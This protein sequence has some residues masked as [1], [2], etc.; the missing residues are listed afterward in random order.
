MN[1]KSFVKFLVA[2]STASLIAPSILSQS[3]IAQTSYSED[4]VSFYCGEFLDK[5]S[6]E[7][8]PAT[9]AY[10]PQ[11]KEHISI[12]AWKSDHIPAWDA[13]TRCKTVSPK[14]QAFYQ[15]G[16][17][18]YLG[19]GINNGENVICAVVEEGQSCNPEDQLFQVKANDNPQAVLE[20]LTGIIQGDSSDPIYQSTGQ[21]IYVSMEELLNSAP[22][23]E[24]ADLTSN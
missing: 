1:T 17:L 2:T 21:Q 15:D 14:F 7:K 5:T 16:R 10:V 12:I 4:G 20:G 13:Q 19:T 11:R 22:A 3:S 23:I 8:I 6:G 18:N 9:I 24:E